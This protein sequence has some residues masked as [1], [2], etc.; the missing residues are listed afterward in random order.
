M[1]DPSTER[2]PQRYAWYVVVVLMLVAAL[3]LVD[4]LLV[5]QLVEPIRRD[6]HITDFEASLLIGLS[7]SLPFAIAGIPIGRL[8]DRSVRRTIIATGIGFWSLMTA[9]GGLA[10][11]F[12]QLFLARAGVG[13]GEAALGPAAYSI[14]SDYFSRSRLPVAIAVFVLGTALGSGLSFV[15]GGWIGALANQPAVDLPL[16]GTLR[17]WQVAFVLVGLPGLLFAAWVLTLREPPR[18][19]VL[20][21]GQH[22][23][24]ADVAAF[25]QRHKRLALCLVIGIGSA[26]TVSYALLAWLTTFFIR[27]HGASPREVGA[28]VG[29]VVLAT[30][31]LGILAGG[32][33]SAWLLR[34]GMQDATLRTSMLGMALALPFLVCAPEV[35]SRLLSLALFA[36]AIFFASIFVSLGTSTIQLVTPNEMRAQVSALGLMLT[37][38]LGSVLGPSLVAACTDPKSGS[39]PAAASRGGGLGGPMTGAMRSLM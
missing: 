9:A 29:L 24:V 31:A 20:V 14:I 30:S 37:T 17:G 22:A 34:R 39:Y 16:L 18:R 4:R 23:S 35:H 21:A 32:V 26:F 7:F 5:A 36:P 13:V 11:S 27:V 15:V 3:S 12:W 28:S 6:L 33:V 38:V 1:N 19:D 8:A 25:L 10:Q 2:P